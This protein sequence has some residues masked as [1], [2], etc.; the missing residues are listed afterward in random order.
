MPASVW[1]YKVEQFKANT[2]PE[3]ATGGSTWARVLG[4]NGGLHKYIRVLLLGPRLTLADVTLKK[5]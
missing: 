2:F 4:F 5:D 1:P 3:A